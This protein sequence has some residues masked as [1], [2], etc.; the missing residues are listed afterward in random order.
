MAAVGLLLTL[1]GIGLTAFDGF[2]MVPEGHV[3]IV[4][5]AGVLQS[6]PYPTGVHFK[7]P[8][9]DRTADMQ[10]TMQTDSVTAIPCGT[11]GGVMLEFDRIEV[12]NRLAPK[13]VISTVRSFGVHYDK[14][15]IFDKIHHEINQFCS[16]HTLQQVYID[17][18]DTLDESLAKALQ[19]DCDKY[20]TGI[21][22]ITV[23][24]TKPKIP[25]KVQEQYNMVEAQR[26]ALR[27]SIEAHKVS[28]K[29]AETNA[30]RAKS[31]AES[32]KAVKEVQLAQEVMEREAQKKI[33]AIQDEIFLNQQKSQSDAAFYKAQKESEANKLKLTK[34]YLQL[35]M[36]HAIGNS[37]KVY[38]GDKLPTMFLN[39]EAL[40][41]SGTCGGHP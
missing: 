35:A 22:I 8:L 39:S 41:P 10:I 19:R 36:Y 18:F 15:W 4:W 16:S 14:M 31:K 26:A 24:V 21:E 37:T 23:R 9:I 2:F 25:M 17:K 12:V 13:S 33:M 6:H 3:G 5:R 34:E 11:S 40:A 27:V 32:E 38:F 7:I 30:M 1:A 28:E 20:E 29:E